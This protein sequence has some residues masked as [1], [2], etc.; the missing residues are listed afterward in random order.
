M[1]QSSSYRVANL[2][3]VAGLLVA[4][5]AI[6]FFTGSFLKYEI[7]LLD[8]VDILVPPPVVVIGGLLFSIILNLYP[9]VSVKVRGASTVSQA[10]QSRPWNV[11]ILTISILFLA[12]LIG[13]VSLENL[14]ER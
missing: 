11:I 7:S 13:Y 14:M 10:I 1:V 9:I 2:V 8:N 5:P 3:A 6:Y 4:L 12:A